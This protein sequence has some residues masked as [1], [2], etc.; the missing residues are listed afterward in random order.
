MHD[1]KFAVYRRT[2]SLSSQ[3]SS[4]VYTVL[5]EVSQGTCNHSLKTYGFALESIFSIYTHTHLNNHLP[6]STNC[7]LLKIAKLEM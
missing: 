7:V 6:T 4:V 2:A 1:L 3:A 5:A